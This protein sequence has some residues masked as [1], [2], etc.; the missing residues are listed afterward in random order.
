MNVPESQPA[1]AKPSF[2][3]FHLTPGHCLLALL[4]IDFLLFLSQWCCWLPKAWP[5]LIAV[6]AVGLVML[7]MV[8]WFGVALVF[9]RRFQFS[10]RSLL[11]LVVV[12]ALPCSWMAVEMQRAKKQAEACT[13]ISDSSYDYDDEGEPLGPGWLRDLLGDD[14]F[15]KVVEAELDDNTQL[16][17]LKD[18][19]ELR[20]LNLG[21]D[22]LT[23]AAL[24]TVTLPTQ[25][26]ELKLDGSQVTDAGMEKLKALPQ[27]R[28]LSLSRTRVTDAAM[29]R[30]VSALPR[31][32]CLDLDE[33]RVTDAGLKRLKHLPQIKSLGIAKT[34]VTDAGLEELKSLPQLQ[35]L[36]LSSSLLKDSGIRILHALPQLQEMSVVD[37]ILTKAQ[38]KRLAGLPH[39]QT[40]FLA[41]D[42]SI[43]GLKEF[44]QALPQCEVRFPY[45]HICFR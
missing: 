22:N 39:L 43:E 42:P 9:R 45:Y 2:R 26:E 32:E 15:N 10:I 25:L 1:V 30:V 29:E 5:V 28:V 35:E 3:R 44:Q 23:D 8:V 38:L 40:L 21:F 4:A 36:S 41:G 24:E 31:L 17:R 14:F 34:E 19:P 33:T 11:V 20:K 7:G 37:G 13:E 16:E 6:A 12:V 27:L 18:L